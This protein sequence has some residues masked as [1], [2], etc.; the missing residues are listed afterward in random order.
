MGACLTSASLVSR[1]TIALHAGCATRRAFGEFVSQAGVTMLGVVPKL[2]RA[3]KLEGTMDGLDWSRIRRFSSTAEPSSPEEMLYLMSLAGYKPVIE[4]C[5]GTEI[6]GGYITGTMVQPCAP[7]AFTT[8]A[9]GLDFVILE[10]GRVSD[11]GELFLIPPSIGLS[12]HLLNYVH[13][14]E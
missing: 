10:D 9:M 13:F 7:S 11:R 12:E 8:A 2:V 3:W 6:G 5:G 14:K 1:P 4:Y